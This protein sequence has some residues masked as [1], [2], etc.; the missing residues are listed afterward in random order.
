MRSIFLLAIAVL[1]A[2]TGCGGGGGGV[3]TSPFIG[4]W[5]GVADMPEP[6]EDVT[7]L[8][9]VSENGHVFGAEDYGTP[10][11]VQF[12]GTVSHSGAL[13]FTD[14]DGVRMTGNLRLENGHIVGTCS[15]EVGEIVVNGINLDLVKQ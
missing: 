6:I 7:M 5:V 2:I 1:V 3:A 15:T 10:E 4:D 13:D 8:F 14:N 9:F 11:A 12:T